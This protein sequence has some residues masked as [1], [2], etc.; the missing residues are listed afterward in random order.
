MCSLNFQNTGKHISSN[1]TLLE[2][3]QH[4]TQGEG[5]KWELFVQCFL[6]AC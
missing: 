3:I 4:V 5:K 1:I 6:G 2:L